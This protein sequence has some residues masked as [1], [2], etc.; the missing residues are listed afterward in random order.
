MKDGT[1][2]VVLVGGHSTGKS[3]FCSEFT[4]CYY[5]YP[6]SRTVP[7]IVFNSDPVFIVV[8]TPGIHNNRN[9]FEYSWQGI[10]RIA[11]VIVDFGNWL[12]SEIY[13]EKGNHNPKY[14]TWSGDNQETMKRI[15]EYL[16]GRK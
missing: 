2:V 11:D 16:Q 8:D 15:Q 12:E 9:I 5:Y 1:P 7:N 14:M 3:R 13:G 6:S 10:F 4:G